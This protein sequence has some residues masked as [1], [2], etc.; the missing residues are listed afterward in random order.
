MLEHEGAW[1]LELPDLIQLNQLVRGRVDFDG[2]ASWYTPLLPAQR[3][4]LTFC[5][6]EF[7]HQAGGL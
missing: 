5:L 1:C 6:C 7:A 4:A 2:F 3:I